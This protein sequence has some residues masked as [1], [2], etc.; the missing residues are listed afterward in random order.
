MRDEFADEQFSFQPEFDPESDLEFP[1]IDL[2][3]EKS[4]APRQMA[5]PQPPPARPAKSTKG[6]ILWPA[7]GFPA[8]IAPRPGASTKPADSDATRCICILLLSDHANLTPAEAAR[9]LR[10]TPWMNR[11]QKSIRAGAPGSFPP[12]D[13]AV[14]RVS[15][16]KPNDKHGDA[17]SFGG[18]ASGRNGV[19]VSLSNYVTRLYRSW[20][21]K[22][23]YEVRVSEQASARLANGLYHVF[24]NKEEQDNKPWS[25]EMDTLIDQY[26]RPR[27][28]QEAGQSWRGEMSFLMN[29]YKFEYGSLHPPYNKY[30]TG[31]EPTEVLHPLFVMRNLGADL[32]IGHVTDTH[33]DVRNDVYDRNLQRHSK[34]TMSLLISTVPSGSRKRLWPLAQ[35]P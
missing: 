35:A 29:E 8:V 25:G 23:L 7:L 6:R 28:E 21:L 14:R 24:W 30:A 11:R 1:G 4:P 5:L 34:G 13:L 31:N 16:S 10:Y 19:I 12:G 9:Y 26:A 33:V 3:G 18:D 22:Y 20:Q 2:E 32:R 15:M 17:L 27:R